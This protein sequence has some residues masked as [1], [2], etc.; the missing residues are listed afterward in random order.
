MLSYGGNNKTDILIS[1]DLEY[2]IK[3]LLIVVLVS[4]DHRCK[5]LKIPGG[6]AQIFA[7]ISWGEGV[8]AFVR[9]LNGLGYTILSFI[10]TFIAFLSTNFFEN[11]PLTLH[12][13]CASVDVDTIVLSFSY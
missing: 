8:N 10:N 13:L 7:K 4:V 12:P 3:L 9:N 6:I 11:N 1:S 5:W 2:C